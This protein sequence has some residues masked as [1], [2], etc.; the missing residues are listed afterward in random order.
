MSS[1][2]RRSWWVIAGVFGLALGLRLLWLGGLEMPG[3]WDPLHY[4]MLG[5]NLLDGRGFVIDYVWHFAEHPA[6]VTHPVD[7]WLPLPGV[8]AAGGMALAG[9]TVSAAILPFA[10]LGA[11]QAALAAWFARRIGLATPAQV[12]AGVGT[13]FLPPLV[14]ASLHTDT[15][16]PFSVFVMIA[17]ITLWLA[18]EED[19]R[20]LWLSGVASGLALLTRNDA[21]L[22]LP[23][24]VVCAVVYGLRGGRLRPVH[25]VGY[26]LLF[27][28]VMLPWLAR[29]QQVLGNPW[30]GSIATSAFVRDHEEFYTYATQPTLAR[31]LEWGVGNIVRKWVFELVASLKLMAAESGPL[32]GTALGGMLAVI[33]GWGYRRWR[34]H[35]DRDDD[36]LA[37][38]VWWPLVPALTLV[39]GAWVFYGVVTPFLSQGGSFKKLFLGVLPLL[40]VGGAGVVCHYLRDNAARWA[41]V[42]L[43]GIMLLPGAF[44]AVRDD[45]AL[46]RDYTATVA[47]ISAVLDDLAAGMADELIVMVRD[48]WTIHYVGGYRT[49][50]VPMEPLPAILD[51]ADEYGVTHLL[52]PAPRP[53]LQ[54]IYDETQV[55]P[56][57]Q[58]AAEV[59]DTGFRIYA[60][61][62]PG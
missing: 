21:V 42:G 1:S 32:W 45:R 7:H 48:P 37:A 28:L 49:V 9:R 23:T 40:M 50:M 29:N 27:A 16:T 24:L 43:A 25:Y 14:L 34:G 20:W 41:V 47:G 36:T 54:P 8:L 13:A 53:A 57:L 22:L 2:G 6:A 52:L 35:P 5:E 38:V 15:T 39:L 3:L 46:N 19:G 60:V 59:P 44:D 58:L 31:Y 62:P 4:F 33:A 10:V 61:L 18:F 56:R 51:A 55:E 17:L 11:V 30:P 12:L 26:V